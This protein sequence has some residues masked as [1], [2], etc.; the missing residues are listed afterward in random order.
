[1]LNFTFLPREIR[2]GAFRRSRLAMRIG[3]VP[4]LALSL[5]AAD[6]ND[7]LPDFSSLTLQELSTIKVTSVSKRQQKLSQ[8]AAAIYVLTQEE[9]H[10]SGMTNIADLLRL[11]PGLSVARIDG[12]KW[13]VTSRGF[14]GRFA[15]TLLVMVDG[16]S[17]YT[18]IFGGVYWDMSMPLLDNIDRIEVIRGAGAAVWGSNAV[19]GVINIITKSAGETT[20]VEVTTSAGSQNR[21]SVQV[22]AGDR[23]GG[24]T[25]YRTY[26]S[27]ADYSALQISD[28]RN[29]HDGWSDIQGGFRLDGTYRNSAWQLEGDLFH[30]SRGEASSLPEPGNQFSSA[31]EYSTEAGNSGD[32]AFEW[33][34]RI[35]DTSDLRFNSSFD[36]INRPEIGYAQ[37]KT[38]TG[39]FDLQ[40]HFTAGK[41]HDIS[42]GLGDRLVSESVLGQGLSD[43]SPS[44]MTYQTASAFA[45]DEIHLLD[46]RLLLTAGVKVEH[47]VLVGWQAQ[48]TARALWA[49]NKKH[50]AWVSASRAVRAPTFY[51]LAVQLDGAAIPGSPSTLGLPLVPSLNGSAGYK[52][53]IS[54]DY[55]LGYRAQLSPK[56][57]IDLAGFY[58]H[59]DDHQTAT[60]GNLSIV[61]GAQ[62]YLLMP[63]F[64]TNF[65]RGHTEGGEATIS[66]H[67]VSGW[68]MAA[69]YS[70]LN[71]D[72]DLNRAAPAGTTPTGPTATP[73]HQVKLQSYW[74]VSKSVELDTLLFYSNAFPAVNQALESAIIPAHARVD[75]RLGWRVKSR[76]ELSVVG[77]DLGSNQTLELTPDTESPVRYTSRAFYVKSTFRF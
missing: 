46:D 39:N 55:E 62:P 40:Y 73:S 61:S 45:Q 23:L 66:Y 63:Y 27:A 44:V 31:T 3:L 48:P 68:K 14:N 18:P 43:F 67:P 60:T 13:A 9:I 21:G 22:Q 8:V 74:N 17:V 52:P 2:P 26:I 30:N 7:S 34:R 37:G 42:V 10:R 1:M 50:S 36:Y 32:L 77:Q 51:E 56:L 12:S 54:K 28:G 15:N 29:A 19:S 25:E 24:G 69:S 57:S 4:A 35:S 53:E 70:Y 49:P 33:R 41:Y 59:F 16:R 71:V 75:V 47:D 76:W 72:V 65:G 20:G 64:L 38:S 58:T 11:V 5:V 6:S